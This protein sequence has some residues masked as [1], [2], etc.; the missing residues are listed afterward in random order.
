MLT[1][2]P[3]LLSLTILGLLAPLPPRALAAQ[4]GDTLHLTVSLAPA[5]GV[6]FNRAGPSR[7]VLQQPFGPSQERRLARGT[8]WREDAADDRQRD[9]ERVP[10]SAARIAARRWPAP[11]PSYDQ[12]VPDLR[13]EV[14]L[15][16][17]IEPGPHPLTLQ[18]VIYLCD[19]AHHAC[20][21]V[22]RELPMVLTVAAQGPHAAPEERVSI[23]LASPLAG[24]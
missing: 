3:A 18:A 19:G 17:R 24:R 22:R 9:P 16:A 14:P 23:P 6:L 8:P 5:P 2:L 4:P 15:P 11:I 12:A 20:F 10:S 7:L 13:F 21:E 1:T